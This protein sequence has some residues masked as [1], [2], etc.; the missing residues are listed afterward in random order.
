MTFLG[1]LHQIQLNMD[2]GGKN[3][4]GI[5]NDKTTVKNCSIG[6]HR[7]K[8]NLRMGTQGAKTK[9]WLG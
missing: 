1:H 8:I 9:E 6:R 5:D 3:S 4:V 2:Q 7:D